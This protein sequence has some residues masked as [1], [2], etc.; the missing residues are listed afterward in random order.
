MRKS[1]LV[2]IVMGIFLI[3]APSVALANSITISS[4]VAGASLN[5]APNAVSI[6]TAVA[7]MD[8]GN[9]IVVNDPD[10]RQVDDGSLTINA[11]SAV[12]GLKPL[13]LT[14][15]YTVNYT[16]LGVNDTPLTGSYTFNFNAPSVISTPSAATTDTSSSG[17]NANLNG[18]S[19]AFVYTLLVMALFVLIFL[20]WYAKQ[21]F[22]GTSTPAS[23]KT[24][25]KPNRK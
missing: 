5:V 12:V 14:G 10:G 15:V 17:A 20:I 2:A 19:N 8:Q 11:N 9:Q 3:A 6:T 1:G 13:T 24:T 22:G 16:L 21:S 4:P 7:L 23:T 25:R 18:G